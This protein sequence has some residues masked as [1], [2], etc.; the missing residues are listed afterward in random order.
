MYRKINA[1][2]PRLSGVRRRI[3]Q[4]YQ[5]KLDGKIP[6]DFW[7]RKMAEWTIEEGAIRDALIRLEQPTS[8][9]LLTAQRILELA[10]KAYSLYLTRNPQEQAHLL[11]TV[12]LNCAIDGATVRPTYRKPFDL[13]FAR[14]KDEDWSGREHLNLRP[15]WSRTKS[16]AK[17]KCFIWRRLGTRKPLFFSPQLYLVVPNAHQNSY[18]R[19]ALFCDKSGT[20]P[21]STALFPSS[22][23]RT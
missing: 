11:R 16:R 19:A 1:L 20:A 6:E 13:I 5:D 10:N 22:A 23:A 15:P 4:A 12:L 21:M 14:A 18:S 2:Q 9:R 17:S 8:E 3:D 7:E